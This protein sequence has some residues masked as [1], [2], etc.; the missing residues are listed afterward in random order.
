MSERRLRTFHVPRYS[1]TAN[2]VGISVICLI[3]L[4]IIA[5]R[6]HGSDLRE[7]LVSSAVVGLLLWAY[8]T[9]LLYRGLR[10]D[11]GIVRWRSRRWSSP[12]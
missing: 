6:L 5:W 7:T 1:L 2:I 3:S 8:F 12:M 11:H 4:I 9:V 10:F